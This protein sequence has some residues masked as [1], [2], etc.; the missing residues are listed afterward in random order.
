MG[1][2]IIRASLQYLSQF[3][4]KFWTFV[5]LSSPHLGY[6]AHSSQLV[7]A[8]LW[9]LNTWEKCE[10]ISQLAMVDNTQL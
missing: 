1:G 9:Y 10:S 6:L 2:V 8:G 4:S 7:N 5:S 3:Y